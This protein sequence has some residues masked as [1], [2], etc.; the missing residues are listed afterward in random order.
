MS[1]I[2]MKHNAPQQMLVHTGGQ[3]H[4]QLITGVG[5]ACHTYK[6]AVS[7]YKNTA[8]ILQFKEKK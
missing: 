7:K 2:F 3:I 6:I 8:V 4:V 5:S 1:F